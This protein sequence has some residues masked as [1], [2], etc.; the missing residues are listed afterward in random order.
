MSLTA[1]RNFGLTRQEITEGKKL[2]TTIG[3]AE[4]LGEPLSLQEMHADA[5][6]KRETPEA[7]DT[8]DAELAARDKTCSLSNGP[9]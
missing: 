8:A 7:R 9:S 5:A 3:A 4:I 1:L 2:P 6:F